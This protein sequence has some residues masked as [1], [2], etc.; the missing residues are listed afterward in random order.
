MEV[1][2]CLQLRWGEAGTLVT[3]C[4]AEEGVRVEVAGFGVHDYAVYDAVGNVALT[5]N[6]VADYSEKGG[7]DIVG[8][9]FW[10]VDY[11]YC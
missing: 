9:V 7:G 11:P 6:F 8:A 10:E 1:V 4:C 2:Q 5:Q 3:S